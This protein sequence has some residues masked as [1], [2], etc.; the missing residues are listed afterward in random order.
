MRRAPRDKRLVACRF[1][2]EGCAGSRK[3]CCGQTVRLGD[4][5]DRKNAK[6]RAEA[7]ISVHGNHQCGRCQQ[8][9]SSK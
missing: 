8:T 3:H 9:P 7:C 5:S 2:W 6:V 4:P 1:E